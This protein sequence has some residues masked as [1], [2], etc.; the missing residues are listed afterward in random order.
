LCLKREK[1]KEANLFVQLKSFQMVLLQTVRK[2]VIFSQNRSLQLQLGLATLS[3]EF[4]PTWAKNQSFDLN[5]HVM[6]KLVKFA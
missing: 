4:K 2:F 6:K 5:V 3:L 1:V